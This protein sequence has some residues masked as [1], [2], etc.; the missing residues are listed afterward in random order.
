MATIQ[1]FQ[2]SSPSLLCIGKIACHW[3]A[4][5][6]ILHCLAIDHS[7]IA[8]QRLFW[9][10]YSNST[11]ATTGLSRISLGSCMQVVQNYSSFFKFSPL[12][13]ISWFSTM[14]SFYRSLFPWP[15]S[16][17]QCLWLLD[18][19]E[20]KW[21]KTLMMIVG[22]P[23]TLQVILNRAKRVSLL[24]RHSSCLYYVEGRLS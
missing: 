17:G 2:L 12:Q 22:C 24:Y 18:H 16:C 19:T 14:H 1:I 10:S 5:A 7:L 4:S 20:Q 11:E 13:N 8:D 3:T 6:S 23:I 21:Q 15:K 9:N